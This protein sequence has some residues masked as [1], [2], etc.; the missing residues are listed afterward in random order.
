MKLLLDTHLLLWASGQPKKLSRKARTLIEAP[1][2][3]LFFSAASLWEVVIKRALGREDFK[4]D[5]RLLRRGLLDNGYSELP[6]ASEHV[7]AVESLPAIHKD[8]FDRILV[9]QA[10]VEGFALL[11]ADST[12]AQYGGPVRSV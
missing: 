1:D 5:P 9:A 10:I 4:V 3:E 7:V 8:P 12:V 11:T 6:V 2:N